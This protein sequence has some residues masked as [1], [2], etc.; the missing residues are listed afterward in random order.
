MDTYER[1]YTER[2]EFRFGEFFRARLTSG[3]YENRSSARR[4]SRQRAAMFRVFN[5]ISS[6]NSAL[7]A[8]LK[9]NVRNLKFVLLF[10]FVSDNT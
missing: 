9:A 6:R 5:E 4:N 10:L 7:R 8:E 2:A 3:G 1:G